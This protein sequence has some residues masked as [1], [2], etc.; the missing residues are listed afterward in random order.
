MINF[1]TADAETLLTCLK[2]TGV[3]HLVGVLEDFVLD[4]FNQVLKSDVKH[5]CICNELNAAL[6][7]RLGRAESLRSAGR[8]M[9]KTNQLD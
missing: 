6:A 8:S 3:D 1:E 4:F 7:G 2:E 5:V 9:V